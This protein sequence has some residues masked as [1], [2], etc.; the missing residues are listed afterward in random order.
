MDSQRPDPM[1]LQ[2]PSS[3]AARGHTGSRVAIAFAGEEERIVLR[4]VDRR[5][6]P[7]ILVAYL[8]QQLDKST[9]AYA[10][11]FGIADDANLVG[12]QLSWLGSILYLASLV[13]QPLTAM[14]L[15]K[16]PLGKVIAVSIFFWGVS[17]CMMSTCTTFSGLLFTRFVLGA[18]EAMIG[19]DAFGPSARARADCFIDS[20]V[21]SCCDSNVVEERGADPASFFMER[22]E[23]NSTRG[24]ATL[25]YVYVD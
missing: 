25:Q 8:F 1:L 4:K 23:W 20:A 12:K 7:F 2:D 10:S 6:L 5:I 18:F 21:V 14:T 16:Y 15:V 17:L 24:K 22:H 19:M 13:A 3:H 9:L 11:V